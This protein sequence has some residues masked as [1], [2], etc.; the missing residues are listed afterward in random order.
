M[1]WYAP[2]LVACAVLAGFTLRAGAADGFRFTRI[3]QVG[4][5]LVRREA[6]LPGQSPQKGIGYDGQFYFVIAQDPF[7]RHAWTVASLDNTLRYRR[8][9]Y[10]LLA[11]G[12]SVGQRGLVPYALIGVNVA[13]MGALVALLAAAAERTL[14][15][16]WHA[17]LPAAF[18]GAWLPMLLDLTEPTHMLLLATA[19]VAGGSAILLGLATLAKETAAVALVTEAVRHARGRE[20]LAAAR[21]VVVLAAC[22]LW[23]LAVYRLL[24]G[25]HESTLGGHLLDPP[26]APLLALAKGPPASTVLAL[27]AVTIC[28]LAIARLWRAR[29]GAAWA[30]AAYAL[31]ALAAGSDTWTDPVAYYRVMAGSVVLLFL[32]WL[33]AREPVGTWALR[34]AAVAGALVLVPVVV[35]SIR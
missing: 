9:L 12:G 8:L 2:S 22:T 15:N 35:L 7:L 6:L 10:P 3:I 14:G 23:A 31:L 20:W 26:G 34:L 13:A 5:V 16:P 32:S 25:A 29:D 24:R 27:P 21:H 33:R 11:Y 4:D 19:F 28:V 17:L 1:R 18:P 30:A